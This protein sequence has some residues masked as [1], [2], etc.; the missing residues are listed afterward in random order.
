M[1]SLYQYPEEQLTFKD[2]KKYIKK[3]PKET[4]LVEKIEICKKHWKELRQHLYMEE[5]KHEG[6]LRG[7]MG[8]ISGI[9]IVV[10][11]Y[12]KKL[13]FTF[14]TGRIEKISI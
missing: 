8:G 12:L 14:N 6:V 3:L 4:E 9:V 10:K 2:L 5:V 13:R 1:N 7:M 11:P